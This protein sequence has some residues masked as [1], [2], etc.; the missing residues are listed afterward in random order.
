MIISNFYRIFYGIL[1]NLHELGF[2]RGP[3][4]WSRKAMF[5]PTKALIWS[6]VLR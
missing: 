1:K 4:K 5:E 6:L 3:W 2:A